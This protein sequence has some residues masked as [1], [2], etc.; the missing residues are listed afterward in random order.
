MLERQANEKQHAD[1]MRYGVIDISEDPAAQGFT[2]RY[3]D[4]ILLYDVIQ[5]TGHIRKT[6][7]NIKWL[8][9]DG[10]YFSF[11]QTCGGSD[12]LNMIF[13]YAPDSGLITEILRTG[14][15]CG[16]RLA[17]DTVRLRLR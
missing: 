17:G 9:S 10:G 2:E 5:A 4:V 6:I 8:L 3:F 7:G 14:S 15:R 16:G 12:M 1:M 11:V 13:G